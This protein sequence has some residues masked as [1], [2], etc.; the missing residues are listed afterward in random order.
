MLTS[1]ELRPEEGPRIRESSETRL[2]NSSW[3]V[4]FFVGL[5]VVM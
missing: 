5:L 2:W 4:R 1:E 3:G